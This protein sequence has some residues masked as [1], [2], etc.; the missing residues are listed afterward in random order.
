MVA[1]WTSVSAMLAIVLDELDLD[2][3]GYESYLCPP[4]PRVMVV[5][6]SLACP[7]IHQGRISGWG[8]GAPDAIPVL[9]LDRGLPPWADPT[10]LHRA[11]LAAKH[12]N[13]SP[14]VLSRHLT[15]PSDATTLQH[16]ASGCHDG[17]CNARCMVL[18]H[19]ECCTVL[20]RGT[21]HTVQACQHCAAYDNAVPA[22]QT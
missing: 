4:H 19:T 17:P 3:T 2:P 20:T 1:S 15:A 9:L 12:N 22:W 14:R 11:P 6:V 8:P 21:A 5:L 7:Q 18:L 13:I 10:M 16:L